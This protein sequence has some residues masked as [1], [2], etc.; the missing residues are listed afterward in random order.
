MLPNK[1]L[2]RRQFLKTTTGIVAGVAGFPYLVP[3]HVLG[4]NGKIAPGNKITVG[5]IGVGWMG[6]SNMETFLAEPDV[7][8]TAVCDVDKNHL[9]NAKRLVD[10]R[11]SGHFSRECR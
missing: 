2:A 5:C 6:T 1:S 3:S 7:Q 10:K 11:D 8:V 9:E 4:K